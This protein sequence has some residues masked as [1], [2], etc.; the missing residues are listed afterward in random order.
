M[1]GRLLSFSQYLSGA[2]AVKVVEMFPGDQRAFTYNF[3]NADVS[4]YTFS[5]D[6]QSLLLSEVTYNTTSGEPNFASTTVSG[7]FTNTSNVN[8]A[9][10]INTVSAGSGLVTLTIPENRYTG[11]VL[12]NARSNVV[13][14]VLSFQW[15]TA[16]TPPQ[17]QRHRY[18]ILERFDPEVGKIP[19]DPADESN[20][21]A[22]T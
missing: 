10:Y 4:G 5:A 7:Y 17:K 13:C 20:F 18:A 6:Y 14:T 3:N 1:S 2:D 21:V 9:T 12:P 11:N 8:A 16:D 19:G 22:L 15:E